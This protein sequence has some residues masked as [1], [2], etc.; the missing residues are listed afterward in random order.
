ME[1]AGL[2]E[3]QLRLSVFAIVFSSMAVLELLHPRLERPELRSALKRSRWLTNLGMLVLSSFLLRLVFPM[4][5]VGTALY[6]QAHGFGLFALIPMGFWTEAILSFI[7]LDFAIWAEHVASHKI[8]FLW[9]IHRVHHAD[10]GI[11]VTTAL[12]FHPAEILISMLW[13]AGLILALGAPPEAVLVFEIVLNGAAM[14]NHANVALPVGI[15]KVLRYIIV[16]PDM[17][18]IHHSTNP[19][20]TDSNFGFNLSIWDRLFS[21]YT[22]QPVK[23]QTDVDIGLTDTGK[24]LPVQFFWSLILPFRRS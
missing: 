9:R 22:A 14:F 23:G 17:H 11:D 10:P 12:R 13:K 19:V 2:S 18:R 8:A 15:D 6:A 16:T 7:L 24:T 21:L 4:A 3:P 1:L 20:E 5:A